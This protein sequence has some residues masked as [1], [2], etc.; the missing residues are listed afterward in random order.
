MTARAV[1]M[2]V[3]ASP[4]PPRF[5]L[6][7]TILLDDRDAAISMLPGML[8]DGEVTRDGLRTWPLFDRLRGTPGFDRLV[9]S[10]DAAPRDRDTCLSIGQRH[11]RWEFLQCYRVPMSIVTLLALERG[12][13]DD[14]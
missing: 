5:R 11:I 2:K 10:E 3:A 6:A 9:A 7:R 4:P 12:N 14:R 13:S 1:A 8:R